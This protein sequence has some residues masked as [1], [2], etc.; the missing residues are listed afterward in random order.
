MKAAWPLGF[1]D[2]RGLP[3]APASAQNGLQPLRPRQSAGDLAL[4]IVSR[5]QFGFQRGEPGMIGGIEPAGIGQHLFPGLAIGGGIGGFV[6]IVG[7][8][9]HGI[10][11]GKVGR[12]GLA[13]QHRQGNGGKQHEGQQETHG[14]ASLAQALA[15]GN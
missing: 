15:H 8:L 13:G 1:L 9:A 10:E 4:K 12:C 5:D 14:P 11:P 2:Q 6:Q 3:L 7:V